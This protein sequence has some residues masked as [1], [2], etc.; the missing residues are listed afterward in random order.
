MASLA[1]FQILLAGD[2]ERAL[3]DYVVQSH[4]SLDLVQRG[5]TIEATLPRT[6]NVGLD[7]VTPNRITMRAAE[8]GEDYYPISYL[9]WK[10]GFVTGMTL[11]G[12]GPRYFSTS[13]LDGCRFTIKFTD[14]T[15]TQVTVLHGAGRELS[16]QGRE[17]GEAAALASVASSERTRRYSMTLGKV[18]LTPF[19]S[20]GTRQV[21]DGR[22]AWIF[23]V[24]SE[25]G[26]WSFGAQAQTWDDKF[27]SLKPLS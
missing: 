3:R 17:D 20:D 15:R 4:D 8:T 22:K 14:S 6:V 11:D 16:R 7:F 26:Q 19:V 1:E 23:G 10:P 13:Q 2:W 12:T 21:Y 25:T 27:V 24:R 18:G 9:P 5:G